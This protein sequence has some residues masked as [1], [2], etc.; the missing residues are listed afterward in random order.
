MQHR[1][2]TGGPGLA[3]SSK[4]QSAGVGPESQ[5]FKA[6]DDGGEQPGFRALSLW[7]P[8]SLEPD[9]P[10]FSPH[11]RPRAAR[12]SMRGSGPELTASIPAG[13]SSGAAW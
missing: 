2:L 5:V 7:P 6:P 4:A 10:C 11:R 9:S 13:G 12:S 3:Q 1:R 8:K